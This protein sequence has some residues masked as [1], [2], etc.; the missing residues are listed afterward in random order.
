M[1]IATIGDNVIDLYIAEGTSFVG[2]NCVNVAVYAK[3]AGA[4][5]AAYFGVVGT[6]ERGVDVLAALAAENVDTS[7]VTVRDG[8]T[9]WCKIKRTDGDRSF[10]ES[11]KG[12]SLFRV[13]DDLLR[14]VHGF[15]VAHMAYS[16]RME[17]DV[18]Y[19]SSVVPVSFD[20]SDRHSAEYISEIAPHVT[21]A[22]FSGGDLAL[23]QCEAL[24]YTAL[25]AGAKN[26]LVSRGAAGALFWSGQQAPVAVPGLPIDVVDTLGAGDT[27]IATFLVGQFAGLTVE[28]SLVR[29]TKHAAATCRTDGGFGRPIP[30]YTPIKTHN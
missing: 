23:E 26:V 6:D 4:E 20:F 3:R 15:D 22:T 12:V 9:A 25:N 30:L 11:D 19:V 1:K 7:G 17:D 5:Q 14:K 8:A 29:A 2:G 28:E 21:Y 27:L 16:G 13:D 24:A 10:I 18:K